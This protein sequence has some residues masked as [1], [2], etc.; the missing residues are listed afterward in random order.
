MEHFDS[1]RK[2]HNLYQ[3][4]KL[5][6]K[7]VIDGEQC[8]N[9]NIANINMSLDDDYGNQTSYILHYFLI[10]SLLYLHYVSVMIKKL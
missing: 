8:A 3:G 7:I 10:F 9:I 5:K 2:I 4:L 6:E 1:S